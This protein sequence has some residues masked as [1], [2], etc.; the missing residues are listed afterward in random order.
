M[1][2]GM[3]GVELAEEVR[4]RFPKLPI[5]LTSGYSDAVQSV[6]QKGLPHIA[7]PY[8]SEMLRARIGELLGAATKR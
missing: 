7:K 8:R 3:N 1:P 4:R 5:L 2:G 6:D